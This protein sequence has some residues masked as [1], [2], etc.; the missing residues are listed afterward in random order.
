M[1]KL[2][3]RTVL[4]I[5]TGFIIL[6]WIYKV[7]R[8]VFYLD[9]IL[10]TFES[11]PQLFMQAAVAAVFTIFSV[12]LLLRLSG[13]EYKDIG[14]EKLAVLKQL[15]N[16]FL[17]GLSIF[18]LDTLLLN[19]ILDAV[20]PQNSPQG[21][22]M[23]TLFKDVH[24]L[25]VFLF[26]ALF[27]GGLS[28]ELWR[29]FILTRFEKILGKPGLILALLLSSAVFGVGH[30]YQGI[31]GMISIGIIGF[32]YA[33]VYLRKKLALEAVTAHAAF[34]LIQVVLGYIVYSGS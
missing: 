27:K 16:G 17:F 14:F 7:I 22:E 19:P 24:F 31:G 34:N 2:P 23:S 8:N 1:K 33:L 20:L 21:I 26:I 5:S 12:T 25:P 18:I 10:H 3:V 29:I 11:S 32:L 4:F 15:R 9:R 6:T 30:L 28:E 13:E